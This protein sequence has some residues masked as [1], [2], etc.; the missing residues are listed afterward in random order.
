MCNDIFDIIY[1][2]VHYIFDIIYN[3]LFFVHSAQF[4]MPTVQN[5]PEILLNI[6]LTVFVFNLVM[7]FNLETRIFCLYLRWPD[8]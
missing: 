7:D 4:V 1:I 5:N 2:Y 3:I 6:A 8:F